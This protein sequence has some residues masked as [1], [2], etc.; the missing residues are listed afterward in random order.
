MA[1]Y[2]IKKQN[3]SKKGK[4]SRRLKEQKLL[5]DNELE[6]RNFFIIL[7]II[8]VIAFGLYFVS[9]AIVSKRSNTKSDDNTANAEIDYSLTTVGT[10]LNR[11]YDDYYVMVYDSQDT[12]AIYFAN[13]FT[14]YSSKEDGLKI[15]FCD[16]NNPLNKNYVSNEE[17]GNSY[18]RTTEDF[19]FGRI[20]LIRVRY[21]QVVSYLEDI[22]QITNELK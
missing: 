21:G 16:L 2:T 7:I 4:S 22:D 9:K 1:K 14:K 12:N 17:S 18:A 8:L 19:S 15:F 20:S 5:N 3:G 10:L 6:I 13:L 11:P